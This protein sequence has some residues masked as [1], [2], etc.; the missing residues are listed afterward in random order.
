MGVIEELRH[1]RVA[2][3]Q[4]YRTALEIDSKYAPARENLHGSTGSPG[5]RG[6]PSLGG[7]SA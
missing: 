6:R 3:Q 7:E 5:E 4:H 2:A 1:N